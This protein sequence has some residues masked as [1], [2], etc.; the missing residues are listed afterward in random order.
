[1]SKAIRRIQS[2][3]LNPNI[4][5]TIH[6]LL[7]KAPARVRQPLVN[8]LTTRLGAAA[9]ER[10]I[11][12]LG[13][14]TALAIVKKV[15]NRLNQWALNGWQWKPRKDDWTWSWEIAVVTGGC[16]GIGKEIV[17]GLIERDVKVV[18]FDIQPL[19]A[20]FEGSMFFGN[21]TF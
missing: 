15:N 21:D 10:L 14:L 18:I 16:S 8:F 12:V 11:K 9:T 17:K 1:M 7:T 5:G 3:A 13:W 4:V 20:E 6:F 19:P 2:A